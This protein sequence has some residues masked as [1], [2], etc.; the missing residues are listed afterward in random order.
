MKKRILNIY[1]DESGVK[2][3]NDK[4][5]ELFLIS[6]VLYDNK[7]ILT[8]ELNNLNNR[9]KQINFDKMIYIND[10]IAKRNDYKYLNIEER[11]YIFNAMYYFIQKAKIKYNSIIIDK[12][13]LDNET[14]LKNKI[15]KEINNLINN[16]IDILTNYNEIIIYYDNGSKIV[17][18]VIS[19]TFSKL[20]GYT[21]IKDFDIRNSTADWRGEDDSLEKNK[22]TNIKNKEI[23]DMFPNRKLQFWIS[24]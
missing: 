13:Y 1:I 18:E 22:V 8:K 2:S 4:T 21:H 12:R 11:R 17:T 7:N 9:L 10:L 5:Q 24:I 14:K 6:Y 20:N 3:I 16:N 15:V 23:D 19:N